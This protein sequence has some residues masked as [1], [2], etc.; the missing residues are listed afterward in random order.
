MPVTLMNR[1]LLFLLQ[2]KDAEAQRDF[3]KCLI[4]SPQLKPDLEKRIA[5]AKEI[6]G[7]K[8]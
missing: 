4:L 3:D 5:F 8:P 6:R 2:G 7:V 1:G